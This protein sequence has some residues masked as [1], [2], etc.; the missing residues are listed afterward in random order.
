Q[1]LVGG[2]D[3][4]VERQRGDVRPQGAQLGGHQGDPVPAT[5]SADR[6][7]AMAPSSSSGMRGAGPKLRFSSAMYWREVRSV[8][9]T[10]GTTCAW[11]CA[12]SVPVN[13]KPT[14]FAS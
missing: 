6:R 2:I 11:A 7:L 10:M 4:G 8:G 9:S 13:M 1:R 14:R 12:M 3:D 5:R